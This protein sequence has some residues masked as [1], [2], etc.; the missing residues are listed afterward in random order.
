MRQVNTVMGVTPSNLFY[1]NTVRSSLGTQYISQLG[2]NKTLTFAQGQ[3]R[4]VRAVSSLGGTLTSPIGGNGISA[5]MAG[6]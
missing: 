5:N 4:N 1:P 3:I 2:G 6:T